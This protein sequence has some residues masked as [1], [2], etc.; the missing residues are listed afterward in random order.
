VFQCVAVCCSV[1]QCV[2]VRFLTNLRHCRVLQCVAVCCSLSQCV[3]MCCSVVLCVYLGLHASRMGFPLS[4]ALA[5]SLDRCSRLVSLSLSHFHSQSRTSSVRGSTLQHMLLPSTF[6]TYFNFNTLQHTSTHYNTLQ[7]TATH[8]NTLE[9][10]KTQTLVPCT[11][12][13]AHQSR[14]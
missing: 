9:I 5:H 4:L 6:S 1:L 14:G 8:F 2:A 11:S 12:S 10:F 3:A 13:L 7:H